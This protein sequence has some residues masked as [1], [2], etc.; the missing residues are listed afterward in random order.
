MGQ[1][2]EEAAELLA[3]MR[4]EHIP[5]KAWY[6]NSDHP[7][8]AAVRANYGPAYPEFW[9][10][11]IHW[12][13][14]K[15]ARRAYLTYTEQRETGGPVNQQQELEGKARKRRSRWE[16]ADGATSN[17]PSNTA[18]ATGSFEPPK[19]KSRWERLSNAPAASSNESSIDAALAAAMNV[20]KPNSS[21]AATDASKGVLEILPGLPAGLTGEQQRELAHLQQRLRIA[22][23]RL[24]NLEVEAARVDA[25]PRGHHD[26]SPSPPPGTLASMVLLWL[27][28]NTDQC[29]K[30]C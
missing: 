3:T 4:G 10:D 29:R 15:E 18:A 19:R 1:D 8:A 26:R 2:D 27:S 28:F 22:N 21:S 24:E 23:E 17:E 6:N 11:V 20:V 16:T 7:T 5:M 30:N 13:G 9:R 25:L 14:W 12:P